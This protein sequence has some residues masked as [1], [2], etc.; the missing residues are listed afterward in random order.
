MFSE[1]DNAYLGKIL[2]KLTTGKTL[3]NLLLES[4]W[5]ERAKLL[6]KLKQVKRCHQDFLDI[7]ASAE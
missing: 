1:S 3:K 6:S 7:M 2:R 5:D 4:S